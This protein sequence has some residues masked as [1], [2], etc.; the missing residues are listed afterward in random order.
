MDH[1]S[2]ETSLANFRHHRFFHSLLGP[3][4]AV[5]VRCMRRARAKLVLVISDAS[6]YDPV[7]AGQ[8]L[9]NPC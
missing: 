7:R 8:S 9:T 4:L 6:G 3:L 1:L 2:R 5:P